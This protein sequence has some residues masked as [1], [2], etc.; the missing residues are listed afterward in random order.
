MIDIG[1]RRFGCWSRLRPVVAESRERRTA[2]PPA[3]WLLDGHDEPVR[4]RAAY[5]AG[6]AGGPFWCLSKMGTDLQVPAH[7]ALDESSDLVIPLP[8]PLFFCRVRDLVDKVRQQPD[9]ALLPQ[10]QTIRGLAIASCTPRFLVVLLD[11][12]RQ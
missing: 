6:V 8:G 2:P 12:F 1:E 10:Q 7:S 4:L 3:R 5:I 9:I 11:R